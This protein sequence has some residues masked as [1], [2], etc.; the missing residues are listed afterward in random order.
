VITEA[1]LSTEAHNP[2]STLLMA[3]FDGLEQM[4]AAVIELRNLSEAPSSIEFVDGNVLEQVHDLNPNQLKEVIARP[5]PAAVLL[6]EFDGSERHLKKTLKR[7]TKICEKY[8][9]GAQIASEPEQQQLFWKIRQATSSLL[10]HNE[11]LQ[12]AAPVIND[13]AVPLDQLQAFIKGVY[14]LL[15]ANNIKPAVWGHA[16]E[17]SLH[18][19]PRFNLGQ[20]GD[21]QKAFRLMEE[22]HKL[23][24]GLGGSISAE[25]GE[26][27]LR[28]PYLETQYGSEIYALFG[29]VKQIFDPYGTLNPGVKFGTSVDDLKAM[30]RPEYSYGHLYDHMP[31]S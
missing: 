26:G 25:A 23:V 28:A 15:Q 10:G 8:S 29:K 2:Q 27:R 31:R 22:Y 17:G 19:Q 14:Q 6:I 16:G 18:V 12:R 1:V 30:I 5:F 20:V 4:Q 9:T 3:S 11:G 24:L 21:R 7:A 13:A